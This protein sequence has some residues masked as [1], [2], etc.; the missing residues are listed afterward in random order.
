MFHFTHTLYGVKHRESWMVFGNY[1]LRHKLIIT[2]CSIWVR[3]LC[4]CT[5][6]TEN[7][8]DEQSRRIDY[9][10]VWFALS[11]Y[12]QGKINFLKAPE[13]SCE[14]FYFVQNKFKKNL[15]KICLSSGKRVSWSKLYEE[16]NVLHLA[17]EN[18]SKDDIND[19][20]KN[21]LDLD[22]EGPWWH[23]M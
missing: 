13:Y 4:I 8:S 11:I 16:E 18:F 22:L 14:T 3:A 1:R 10:C 12:L 17:V 15:L 9:F 19:T 5:L 7:K 2:Y 20:F 23:I 6:I 21:R